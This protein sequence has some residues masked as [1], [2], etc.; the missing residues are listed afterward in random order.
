MH[1]TH[2]WILLIKRRVRQKIGNCKAFSK[3]VHEQFK[4]IQGKQYPI[5]F[6]DIERGGS[7][8]DL[9]KLQEQIASGPGM[10]RKT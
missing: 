6:E 2:K 7:F 4:R 3:K 8:G 9:I 5:A 1:S 10:T